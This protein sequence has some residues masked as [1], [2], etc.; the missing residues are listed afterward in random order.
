MYAT[1]NVKQLKI[2]FG[3]ILNIY[4]YIMEKLVLSQNMVSSI[5]KSLVDGIESACGSRSSA[6]YY[7][8][9]DE[10]MKAIQSQIR[11][12]YGLSK[13]LPLIIANQKG[14][15]GR[16]VSEVLLNEFKNTFK[17]GACNI[18]NPIDWYDKGLSDKAVLGA[19]KNLNENGLP[20]VL[21]LYVDLKNARV[22]NERSRKIFLGFIWGQPNLEF[23]SL[24]Y[25]N[26]I[27]DVL[28][29]IYGQKRTSILLSIAKKAVNGGEFVSTEKERNIANELLL[30]YYSGDS[31]KA[32]KLLL[33]LFKSNENVVYNSTEFP[34]LC[35]YQKAKIDI[36]KAKLV[37]E[38]VLLG[39]I[40]NVRHPQYHLMWSTDAQKVAT[41]ALIRNN[42]EVT[43]VNQQV[44]QTKSTAKLGVEKEVDLEKATD[45]LALYKTGYE[46]GWTDELKTAIGKLA[47]KKKINGFFYQNI[48][49]IVDDSASM[50]GNKNESKN[51]PRAI[52]E[53]TA[54]VLQNSA[55][56]SVVART[57]GFN[58]DLASA[59]IQLLKDEKGSQ[60][61]AIFIV[62]DGYENAYD[63]LTN[64]VISIWQAESGRS[65]PIFQISPITGAEMGA[66]VRKIGDSV[67]TMSVNNP[68]AIQPQI[69]ARLLEVDA[70]RWLESQMIQLESLPI[71]RSIKNNVNA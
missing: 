68:S 29:H 18:V 27:A 41:K 46:N 53:F 25:R 58:T 16:F 63:G 17:G 21:R 50:T 65:L 30:K 39:L 2:L 13:E 26:K 6:T 67:V 1:V 51:T 12:M 38:E 62:T 69:N 34:I 22:N 45:F 20:Y 15:T 23:Y 28:K 64:E 36:T 5:K 33:F 7:H 61:D 52:A 8:S 9:K 55:R 66:N 56:S 57:S 60:Y 3:D 35:E 4:K 14:A 59:F 43:S 19:M 42:V 49:I 47:V 48:G 44:R 40:S 70:K 54:L 31:I 71:S 37:P 11:G 24:K 10:Q 32:F